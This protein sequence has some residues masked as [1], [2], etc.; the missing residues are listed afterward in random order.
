M[1]SWTN[2]SLWCHRPDSNGITSWIK[3]FRHIYWRLLRIYHGENYEGKKWSSRTSRTW[4]QYVPFR[5]RWWVQKQ[6]ISNFLEWKL[7]SPW[8]KNSRHTRTKLCGRKGKS[9]YCWIGENNAS[10]IRPPKQPLGG[11]SGMCSLYL[12]PRAVVLI[13]RKTNTVRSIPWKKT[14]CVLLQN[15]W[16]RRLLTYGRTQ[17]KVL[18][19]SSQM[20][21]GRLMRNK[22]SLSPVGFSF[23]CSPSR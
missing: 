20:Q 9:Y 11:G 21:I 19:K 8:N 7:Y 6:W 17:G 1:P 12:K 16:M 15:I 3:I 23:T 14:G 22:K 10:V 13:Y 18:T 2:H 5:Q 4:N